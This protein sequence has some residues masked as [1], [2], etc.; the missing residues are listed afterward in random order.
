MAV[1]LQHFSATAQEYSRDKIPSLVPHGYVAVDFFFVLSGFI[2]AYTYLAS[3]QEKGFRAFG[4]FLAKRVARIVPLNAV[5]LAIIALAGAAS[6]FISGRNIFFSTQSPAFDF[7]TN[8]L[9]LQGLGIGKNLNAP[10][11]SISVEFA[12]YFL[13]PIFVLLV[14]GSKRLAW[15]SVTAALVGLCALAWTQPRLG[16]SAVDLPDPVIRGF[17]EFTLGIASYRLYRSPHVRSI[18]GRDDVTAG[19][20]LF[21]VLALVARVDLA[22][23]LAFPFLVIAYAVND[24]LPARVV[25]IKPLYFLGVTSF[26]LYLLHN[27]LRPLDLAILQHFAPHPVG[28]PAAL[29]FALVGSLSV[30]PFAWLAYETI[31]KP[32]RKLVRKM[33]GRRA[34]TPEQPALA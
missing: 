9:M 16:L 23:A 11:W 29:T 1:V 12:A 32:G 20:S 2:M 4:P 5:A 27:I 26:S 25:Q 13:F 22:A 6:I 10:S 21:C 19:L 28:G 7:A 33:F 30:I 8:L 18:L 3:F 14:F 24:G 17:T 31:E 34:T 15:V